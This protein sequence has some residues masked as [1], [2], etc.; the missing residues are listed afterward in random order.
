MIWMTIRQRVD[1]SFHGPWSGLW[2]VKTLFLV[3]SNT[4]VY[5]FPFPTRNINMVKSN[6][7]NLKTY[8]NSWSKTSNMPLNAG[9]WT[10]SVFSKEDYNKFILM[11]GGLLHT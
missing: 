6:K 3:D 4:F 1:A 11:V 2:L 10:Y 5:S 8:N 9:L 7:S